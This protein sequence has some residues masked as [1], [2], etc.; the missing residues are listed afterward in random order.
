MVCLVCLP[1]GRSV[2]L[3]IGGSVGLTGDNVEPVQE[4]GRQRAEAS[5]DRGVGVVCPKSGEGGG[6]FRLD[7]ARA[8]HQAQSPERAGGA[9][10]E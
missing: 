6:R 7:G 4:E 8:S 2:C 10:R 9:G 3:W 1:V 5:D